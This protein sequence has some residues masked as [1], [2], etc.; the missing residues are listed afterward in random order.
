MFLG[1][2]T[3]IPAPI[4]V[5]AAAPS[6]IG[7][8]VVVANSGSKSTTQTG[9]VCWTGLTSERSPES[10]APMYEISPIRLSIPTVTRRPIPY[11]SGSVRENEFVRVPVMP[12]KRT[13]ETD[14]TNPICKTV[15]LSVSIFCHVE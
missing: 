12:K 1:S 9:I 6:I 14:V 3:T 7:F 2:V 15:W 10:S 13:A 11:G 8:H 4:T 5:S